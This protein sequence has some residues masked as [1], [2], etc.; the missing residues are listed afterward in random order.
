MNVAMPRGHAG[1]DGGARWRWLADLDVNERGD[2]SF[3]GCEHLESTR[4]RLQKPRCAIQRA[5][6]LAASPKQKQKAHACVRES[7]QS[8]MSC[9]L[10]S[11]T[12]GSRLAR[13]TATR[14][15][16]SGNVRWTRF[17][18][19]ASAAPSSQPTS[20]RAASTSTASRMSSISSFPKWRK[21]M[22]TG[23]AAPRSI[24]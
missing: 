2:G 8:R 17:A 9:R 15:R 23:S 7:A 19:A 6:G 3:P 4:L 1:H 12:A 14:A 13:F 11:I 20:R 16:A 22:F 5:A 10:S 21:P 24:S 18:E